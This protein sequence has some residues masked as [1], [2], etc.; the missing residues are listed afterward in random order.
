MQGIS[1]AMR[2]VVHPTGEED[3]SAA[4]AL[5]LYTIHAAYA[6]GVEGFMGRLSIGYTADFVLTSITGIGDLVQSKLWGDTVDKK[7]KGSDVVVNTFVGGRCAYEKGAGGD[8]GCFVTG[9]DGAGKSGRPLWRCA[10]CSGGPDR[11]AR[12]GFF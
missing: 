2:N 1:D 8:P 3:L 11:R 5:A 6:A 9:P 7:M 10:C 12:G 4:Q